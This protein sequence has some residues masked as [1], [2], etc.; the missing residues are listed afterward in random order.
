MNEDA[1]IQAVQQLY[2]AYGQGDIET[3][4][5]ALADDVEWH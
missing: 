1:N 2:E 3:I 4:L 5:Q